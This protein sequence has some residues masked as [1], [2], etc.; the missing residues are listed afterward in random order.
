MQAGITL[1]G[2]KITIVMTRFH[3]NYFP[4][5]GSVLLDKIPQ[6]WDETTKF[7]MCTDENSEIILEADILST[8]S[9][10]KL[11]HL[12]CVWSV[13]ALCH[14]FISNFIQFQQI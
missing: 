3:P 13:V 1:R 14:I 4:K 7:K 2:K 12:R 11:L 10:W 6:C 9:N 8:I 5:R